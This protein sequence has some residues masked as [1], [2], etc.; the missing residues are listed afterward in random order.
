MPE[1]DYGT[2]YGVQDNNEQEDLR[3]QLRERLKEAIGNRDPEQGE[4]AVRDVFNDRIQIGERSKDFLSAAGYLAREEAADFGK[5]AR[6][7]PGAFGPGNEDH[8][9]EMAAQRIERHEKFLDEIGNNEQALAKGN[10]RFSLAMEKLTLRLDLSQIT[11]EQAKE[12]NGYALEAALL[13]G[14]RSKQQ[15][16][17]SEGAKLA[18]E[19][20][21]QVQEAA[22][23]SDPETR[24][25]AFRKNDERNE[26]IK[27]NMAVAAAVGGVLT[28]YSMTHQVQEL[29]RELAN[30]SERDASVGNAIA[31]EAR[32]D[33]L[34]T[35]RDQMENPEGQIPSPRHEESGRQAALMESIGRHEELSSTVDDRFQEAIQWPAPADYQ[36]AY[37]LDQHLRERSGETMDHQTKGHAESGTVDELAGGIQNRHIAKLEN[38]G[39]DEDEARRNIAIVYALGTKMPQSLLVRSETSE[40]E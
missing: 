12:L 33:D 30:D 1:K 26:E 5:Q 40:G 25:E 23:P 39:L 9:A 6:Y 32:K 29:S 31:Y 7:G 15:L 18:W 24:A 22:Y 8:L 19:A 14:Y 38:G 35:L 10:F 2:R 11:R 36:T 16:G 13:G 17:E 3:E 27:A 28:Q 20:A 34:I 4:E 37:G 21:N